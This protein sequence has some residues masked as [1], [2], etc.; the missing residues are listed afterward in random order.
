MMDSSLEVVLVEW[1]DGPGESPLGPRMLGRTKSQQAVDATREALIEER[2]GAI[3]RLEATG[4]R[5][6]QIL[7]LIPPE[8]E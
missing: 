6:R 3:E 1:P 2:R 5:G 8:E 7:S 4:E